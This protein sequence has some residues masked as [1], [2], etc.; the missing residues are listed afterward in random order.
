MEDAVKT[1]LYA[2]KPSQRLVAWAAASSALLSA[3][4]A[5]ACPACAGTND[6]GPMRQIALGLMILLPFVV[7][8]V[9]VRLVRR[10]EAS[11]S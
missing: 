6:S 1:A 4:I 9:I 8:G 10:G 11:A 3:Q 2:V 5:N 7:A